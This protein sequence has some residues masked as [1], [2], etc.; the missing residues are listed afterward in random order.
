M[1][2]DDEKWGSVPKN[3]ELGLIAIRMASALRAIQIG[4]IAASA[5]NREEVLEASDTVGEYAQKMREHFIQLTGY[6]DED[7]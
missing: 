1:S 3:A 4:L 2:Y 5:G 6:Q 7:E